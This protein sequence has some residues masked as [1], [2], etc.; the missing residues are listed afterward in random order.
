MCE[1][2]KAGSNYILVVKCENELRIVRSGNGVWYRV[3]S[4]WQKESVKEAS[5]LASLRLNAAQT[6]EN[7]MNNR[8]SKI[9]II[10]LNA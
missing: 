6:E 9:A 3:L 5:W 1:A 7:Q 4:Q 8:K 10:L 2:T